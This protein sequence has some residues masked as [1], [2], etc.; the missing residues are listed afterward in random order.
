MRLTGSKCKFP[1]SQDLKPQDPQPIMGS[2]HTKVWFQNVWIS[3]PKACPASPSHIHPFGTWTS[4]LLKCPPLLISLFRE[5]PSLLAYPENSK[6]LHDH[7]LCHLLFENRAVSTKFVRMCHCPFVTY[8]C[9]C[10]SACQQGITT[11]QMSS[12]LQLLT[13]GW[14]CQQNTIHVK[15]LRRYK[16]EWMQWKWNSVSVKTKRYTLKYVLDANRVN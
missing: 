9:F 16:D 15:W 6:F 14:S 7:H 12:I 10:Y 5:N 11:L 4:L 2:E 1:S 3:L 13:Q 8:M